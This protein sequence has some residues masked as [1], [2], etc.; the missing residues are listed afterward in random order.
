MNKF[1]GF[2]LAG[3]LALTSLSGCSWTPKTEK[4]ALIGGAVGAGVGA[5][6][7]RSVGG[8]VV[9]AGI[10]AASGYFL[11]KNSYRCKKI[12]LF[13]QPYWGWCLK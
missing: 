8:A 6:A 3:A 11:A 2:A 12:N 4:G 10:G 13:G 7:T 5:L 9:G 1:A